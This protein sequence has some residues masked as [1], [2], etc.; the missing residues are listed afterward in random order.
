MPSILPGHARSLCKELMQRLDA[1]MRCKYSLHMSEP[2]TDVKVLDGPS[3][4]ALAHPL[5]MRLLAE[6]RYHGPATATRLGERLG[7]SSGATSYHLRVLAAHGFVI[8]ETAAHGGRG[9]ERWWRSAHDMTSWTPG[10]FA[11]DP[12]TRAAEDWMTGY[13]G[14]QAVRLIDD[15]VARRSRTEPEWLAVADQSDYRI[16]MT[17]EQARAMTDEVHAV[18]VRHRQAAGAA[19]ADDRRAAAGARP[20]QLLVYALPQEPEPEPGSGE[21]SATP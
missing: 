21:G 2:T 16:T 8:D 6:L 5:R 15:W 3:L 10:Q 17:P 12:D 14:R 9:R 4:R 13:L 11:A 18:I 20:V 1:N 19:L 7:E